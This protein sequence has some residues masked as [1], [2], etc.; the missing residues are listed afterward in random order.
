[1][2]K[3]VPLCINFLT[4]K[5]PYKGLGADSEEKHEPVSDIDTAAAD[6]LKVLDPKRPIR[7]ADIAAGQIDV[8]LVPKADILAAVRYDGWPSS[9]GIAMK[10]PRRKFLNLAMGATA[11]SALSDT[12]LALDYPTRPVHWIIGFPPGGGADIVARILGAWLAEPIAQQGILEN[13]HCAS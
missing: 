2:K 6:S 12:A 4:K 13:L 1:M 9:R 3:D 7:E 5:T 10:L 11:L 8:R